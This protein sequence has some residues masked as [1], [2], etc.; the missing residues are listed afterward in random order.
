MADA[1]SM[2]DKTVGMVRHH[3]ESAKDAFIGIPLW[4]WPVPALLCVVILLILQT[5]FGWITAKPTQEIAAPVVSSLMA[6]LALCVH[7]WMR[8]TF[9]LILACFA[10]AI[11]FRELHFPGTNT[12]FY[13]AV[14]I[15][16]AWASA[17]REDIR[18]F[19]G[20]RWIAGLLACAVWTY[21]VSKLFDRHYLSFLPNYVAWENNAEESL[22]TLGHVMV[23]A[24]V[25]VTLR[26]GSLQQGR[27]RRGKS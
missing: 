26:L 25:V 1:Y 27:R 17:K 6:G 19:L 9:T 3:A 2:R 21:F 24:A 22:E 7:Y 4:V 12:G 10:V 23:F 11:F 5:P 13:I 18:D 20:E 8:T 15:L 14:V 16:A